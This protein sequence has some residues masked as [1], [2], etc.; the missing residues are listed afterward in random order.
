MVITMK[1][2]RSY[3]MRARAEQAAKTRERILEATVDLAAHAPLAACTLPAIAA[4][5]GASVQTVLRVFGSREGL[6]AAALER[7]R[8]EVLG[9]RDTPVG[10]VDAALDEL[11]R[12]YE[13]RGDAMLMMLG[14]ETWEPVAAEITA[15]ARAQHRDWTSRVFAPQLAEVAPAARD[16]VLDLLAVATDVLTWRILRRDRGLDAATTT[17]R[18]RRLAASAVRTAPDRGAA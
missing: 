8:D 7:A 3:T 5:A 16:E 9:R 2:T 11:I 1:T 15:A 18:M 17:M 4:R 13:R 6:F 12:Q 14:Q 10:D